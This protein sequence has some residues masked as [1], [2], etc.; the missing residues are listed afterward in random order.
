MNLNSAI[1]WAKYI[2]EEAILDKDKNIRINPKRLDELI[3]KI[4]LEFTE[5]SKLVELIQLNA[6][7]KQH[8]NQALVD[9]WGMRDSFTIEKSILYKFCESDDEMTQDGLSRWLSDAIGEF[10]CLE[11]M[12]YTLRF[13]KSINELELA[14]MELRELNSFFESGKCNSM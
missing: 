8:D 7:L 6:D 10:E 4:P 5:N 9:I 3:E 2:Y 14:K 11:G 13:C 12:V 1:K